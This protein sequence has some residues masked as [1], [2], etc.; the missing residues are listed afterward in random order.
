MNEIYD[1][2]QK[3]IFIVENG[4]GAIDEIEEDG[5][6]NDTY[7]I[8]YL[9]DHLKAMIDAIVIDGVPCLGY[10]MWGILDIVSCGPLTMDK[11]YGVVY[12][13]LDNGGKGTGKRIRKDS[14]Y[15]YKK[16]IESNGEDLA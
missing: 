10:T 14:F 11:R 4:L 5:T 12:V 1:R 13:D 16:C 6:I 2:Y 7:R 9:R 8:N 15:W 3:P